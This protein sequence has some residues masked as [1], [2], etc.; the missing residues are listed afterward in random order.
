MRSRL[1]KGLQNVLVAQHAL[2]LVPLF[3][4]ATIACGQTPGGWLRLL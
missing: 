2:S 4:L 1:Y 3:D